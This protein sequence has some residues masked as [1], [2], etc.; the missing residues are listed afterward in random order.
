MYTECTAENYT[1]FQ[2]IPEGTLQKH[3]A[4]AQ[5]I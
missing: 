1:K 4:L 5:N 2:T 3:A